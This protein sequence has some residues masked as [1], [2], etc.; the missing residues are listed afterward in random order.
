MKEK[1]NKLVLLLKNSKSYAVYD[2]NDAYTELRIKP[3]DHIQLEK[4]LE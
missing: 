2:D 3:L 1:F 4:L